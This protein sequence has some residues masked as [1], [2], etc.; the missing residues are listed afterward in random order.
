MGVGSVDGPD[1]SS[2]A[3]VRSADRR[4]ADG[5]VAYYIWG[6]WTADAA[7]DPQVSLDRH[8]EGPC[9]EAGL[10]RR[11]SFAEFGKHRPVSPGRFAMTA[12]TSPV[13][14]DPIA[15]PDER[16]GFAA[17]FDGAQTGDIASYVRL[18]PPREGDETQ[19]EPSPAAV[20]G[21]SRHTLFDPEDIE[22]LEY[23]LLARALTERVPCHGAPGGDDARP[24]GQVPAGRRGQ[25]AEL[26]GHGEHSGPGRSASGV[27]QRADRRPSRSDRRGN[28]PAD[29]HWR[30]RCRW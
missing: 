27:S 20:P 21:T 29:P 22:R 4:P 1:V 14:R 26:P 30:T 6:Q 19:G 2:L 7:R 18:V 28:F 10:T 24:A 5:R 15:Q 8:D 23:R 17:A 11:T 12:K 25:R 3:A 13:D 16:D 9:R